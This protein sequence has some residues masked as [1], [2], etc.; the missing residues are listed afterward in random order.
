M[1]S[2]QIK[3]VEIDADADLGEPYV[4]AC[5]CESKREFD[6][7]I[8]EGTVLLRH[9]TCGEVIDLDDYGWWYE[10]IEMHDPVRVEA[11]WV[12]E[13][14]YMDGPQPSYILLTPTYQP[15]GGHDDE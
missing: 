7:E 14:D 11:E 4:P 1:T 3:W 9:V 2:K 12:I 13:S 8:S 10:A 5:Q 15:L 6:I